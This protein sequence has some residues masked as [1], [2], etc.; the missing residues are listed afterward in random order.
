MLSVSPRDD[1]IGT[2]IYFRRKQ[3]GKDPKY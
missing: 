1:V 3:D 2:D